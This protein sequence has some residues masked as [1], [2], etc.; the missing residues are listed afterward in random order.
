M[1]LYIN[2]ITKYINKK[3]FMKASKYYKKYKNSNNKRKYQINERYRIIRIM[4]ET[5][6]VIYFILL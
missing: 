6:N 3:T 4:N 1:I 2:M 5:Y